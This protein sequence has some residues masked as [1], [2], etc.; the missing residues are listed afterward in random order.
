[1]KN[2]I[3]QHRSAAQSY[4]KFDILPYLK[5][6]RNELETQ[7]DIEFTFPSDKNQF[8][9]QGIHI[10]TTTLKETGKIYNG[11]R[12]QSL[13]NEFLTSQY[14]RWYKDQVKRLP[15]DLILT[16]QGAKHWF[17]G[18]GSLDLNRG[19]NGI[20]S[21]LCCVKLATQSFSYQEHLQLIDLFRNE[22]FNGDDFKINKRN[23]GRKYALYIYRGSIPRFFEYIGTCP[24][25]C[26]MYKFQYKNYWN[27]P[28][29]L[30]KKTI[31]S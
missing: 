1:M 7:Y 26:Y 19:Y 13:S 2:A 3:Y 22:G 29:H 17:V 20:Q 9:S 6:I 8:I 11:Y 12:I 21:Y 18:D 5:L 4:S 31:S 14:Q 24:S 10:N 27:N 30:P 28:Q 15:N 23:N 25:E 16:S